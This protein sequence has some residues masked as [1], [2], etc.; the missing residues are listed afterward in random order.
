MKVAA[1]RKP[2]ILYPVSK[3]S[4]HI[5]FTPEL[6]FFHVRSMSDPPKGY[7]PGSALIYKV[8]TQFDPSV[9]HKQEVF[10]ETGQPILSRGVNTC[11]DPL[12]EERIEH[13]WQHPQI[14]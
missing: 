9:I 1:L 2:H 3:T 11:L 6:Y 10:D 14:A 12:A 7:R 13:Y 4:F 8:S 5:G